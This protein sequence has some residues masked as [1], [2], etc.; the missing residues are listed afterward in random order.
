MAF[1]VIAF[2]GPNYYS[3]YIFIRMRQTKQR[4]KNVT[5]DMKVEQVNDCC[6]FLIGAKKN[7]D[8]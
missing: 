6:T 8:L 2:S 1:M 4:I 3:L 7:Y 5:H